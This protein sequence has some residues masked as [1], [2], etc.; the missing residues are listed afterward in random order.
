MRKP[1]L[2]IENGSHSSLANRALIADGADIEIL[3]SGHVF[4]AKS[5]SKTVHQHSSL[6]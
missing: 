2:A 3:I 6:D 5:V 1:L 4:E